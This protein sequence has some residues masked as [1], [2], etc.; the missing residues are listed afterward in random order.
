MDPSRRFAAALL[1]ALAASACAPPPPATAPAPGPAPGEA[2]AAFR[3]EAEIAAF[4]AGLAREEEARMARA[5]HMAPPP[6]AAPPPPPAAAPAAEESVTNVQHAGVDEGGIVKVHGDHLVVLRRGRLF[7][8]RIGGGGLEP[9]SAVDAFGPGIDPGGAWYD[10]MLVSGDHVVVIGYSYRRGGTELGIFRISPDGRLTH[11]STFQMRSADYYSS[12]NYASRLIGDRLVFYAPLPVNLRQPFAG[13][14]AVRRW[15]TG[16]ETFR[17]TV[18]P[19]RVYRPAGAV[20][21]QSVTLHT[22]TSCDLADAELRCESTALFGPRGR[23]FYVSPS[24]VYVWAVQWGRRGGD[25]SSVLYRM[26]LDGSA[27]TGV[28]VVGAPVDQFSFLESGDGHLNV[29]TRSDARGESMLGSE[30][31]RGRPALLRLPLSELG[32]GDRHAPAERY[33]PLPEPRGHAWQNRFVGDWLVYGTGAGWG[34]P[35]AQAAAPAFAVRWAGGDAVE[36][37]LPHGLDRIE[38]MGSGAVLIGGDGRDL[39]FTG[40]RLGARAAL[41]HRYTR[42]GASQ[43][44]TRSHGF[45]YRAEGEDAG[46]L[47]LPVR[48]PARPGWE[49]LRE[50]SASIVF[51]RNR[52][53]LLREL[54]ELEAGGQSVDDACRASCVDWYGNARPLFLR[55]RILALMGYE[56]VEGVEEGGRIRELRRVSFAPRFPP[57]EVAGA[58]AFTESIGWRGSRYACENRGTMWLDQAGEAVSMRYRQSGEC[59]IAGRTVRSDGEGSGAGTVGPTE[60]RIAVDACQYTG[61]LDGAGQ[62]SGTLRCRVRMPEGGS[63]EVTGRWTATR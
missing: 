1:L 48:G 2:M 20:D 28:R 37:P 58:W 43:G 19:T 47:G 13:F 4:V 54:G 52:D 60:V 22:V 39:H 17:S 5:R 42:P 25:P 6:P 56:L 11:R 63:E 62:I 10:E 30:F 26:P 46:V 40:L 18:E 7:T 41:A 34:R 29:L 35:G 50:G 36:L 3:S 9:V 24:S 45:F 53:F 57:A 61:R 59:T 14:P 44:E 27:P 15:G 31:S 23:V 16:D 33:R 12:R 55:G 21:A 51:L 32:S 49:H 38:A 8:V